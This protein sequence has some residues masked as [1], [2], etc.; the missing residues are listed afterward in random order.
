MSHSP[1]GSLKY[2]PTHKTFQESASPPHAASTTFCRT[3]G[4]SSSA[5]VR[6][7]CHDFSSPFRFH[8]TRANQH[9]KHHHSAT[10]TSQSKMLKCVKN[11]RL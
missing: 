3:G 7:S 11:R 5:G 1:A 8:A 6:S 9:T 2:C 10:A 4:R